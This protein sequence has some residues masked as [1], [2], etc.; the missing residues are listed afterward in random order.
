MKYSPSHLQHPIS[1]SLFSGS[2]LLFLLLGIAVLP[3]H[4]T[5]CQNWDVHWLQQINSHYTEQGNR[6][7]AGFEKS[8]AVVSLAAPVGIVA[9]SLEKN[10]GKLRNRGLDLFFSEVL[11]YGITMALKYGIDR[12][13]PYQQYDWVKSAGGEN[14]PSFPSGHTTGGFV[15]AT[16]ISLQARN[17]WV[18]LL[19]FTWATAVGMGRI[20]Q[21]VH[22]PSDVLAGA[23]I[24][25]AVAYGVYKWQPSQRLFGTKNWTSI[26]YHLSFPPQHTPL[27]HLSWKF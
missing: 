3:L 5:S 7:V 6:L 18:T 27:F 19:S 14:T 20:Y 22:Y 8:V 13:R 15:L 11:A 24:G 4:E 17:I 25:S 10:D 9:V 16:G 23:V 2:F 26:Q 12:Q 21:G 1:S